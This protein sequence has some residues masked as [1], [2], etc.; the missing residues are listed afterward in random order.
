MSQGW[1]L[2][3]ICYD[4]IFVNLKKLIIVCP[5]FDTDYYGND[6]SHY[7]TMSK[8]TTWQECGQ[9]CHDTL[10]CAYWTWFN[11]FYSGTDKNRCLLKTARGITKT[12]NW[13]I[14]GDK[15]C[16]SSATGIHNI[17]FGLNLL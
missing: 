14:S 16:S 8:T 15:N 17:W 12:R 6:I 10:E 9:K 5:E 4:K 13:G 1:H 7:Q 2:L 11:N 3:H